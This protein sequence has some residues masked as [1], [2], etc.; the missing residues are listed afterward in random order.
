MKRTRCSR[1]ISR[2]VSI[3]LAKMIMNLS[4]ERAQYTQTS[5]MI[6]DPWSHRMAERDDCFMH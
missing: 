2:T 5:S 4:D 6:L 1:K 3:F